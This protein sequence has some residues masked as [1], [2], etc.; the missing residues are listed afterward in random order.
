MIFNYS[1]LVKKSWL[2]AWK[3]KLLWFFGLF[4]MA[5][6]EGFN[7]SDR[8]NLESIQNSALGWMQSDTTP[9]ALL[10]VTIV[11][12]ILIL[13]FFIMS[14]ICQGSIIKGLGNTATAVQ[15]KFK[16]LWSYGVSKFWRILALEL[17]FGVAIL[18]L[19]IPTLV[20][21][22]GATWSNVFLV[23]WL[24]L[25]L[26]GLVIVSNFIY[27]TFIY[28]VLEDKKV[29]ESIILGWKL[30]IRYFK[31]SFVV[32]LIR[33]GLSIAFSIALVVIIFVALIP[34]VLLGILFG[35]IAGAIGALLIGILGAIAVVALVL[36]IRGFLNTFHYA[37]GV[38]T[39]LQL[40]GKKVI[41]E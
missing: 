29:K 41:P 1:N 7:Y 2:V 12:I 8:L 26:I 14:V 19:L 36:L 15:N 39:Y 3:N 35:V 20:G 5:G 9:G 10:I 17:L 11:S 22:I 30:F 28:A 31:I 34:F 33:L 4:I 21:L 32:S 18:I 16:P 23:V 40:I 25:L 6:I 38:Y 24:A 13:A 27:Y 37:L